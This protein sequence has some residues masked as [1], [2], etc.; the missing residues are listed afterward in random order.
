MSVSFS[1]TSLAV[2]GAP[3]LAPPVAL[4]DT[5]RVVVADLNVGGSLTASTSTETVA[6]LDSEGLPASRTS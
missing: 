6:V 1:S 2:T 4:S 5:L 3:T